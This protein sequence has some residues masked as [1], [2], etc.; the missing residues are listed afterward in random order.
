MAVLLLLLLLPTV[1][2]AGEVRG[3]KKTLEERWRWRRRCL[4]G[5]RTR[6]DYF[7]RG[8]KAVRQTAVQ[9]TGAGIGDG[10]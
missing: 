4:P 6:I 3:D 1:E 10:T 8:R 2:L 7:Q 9:R 5:R